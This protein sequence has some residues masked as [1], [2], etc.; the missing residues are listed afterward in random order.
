MGQCGLG[1]LHAERLVRRQGHGR[2]DRRAAQQRDGR[3]HRQARR[4]QPLRPGAGRGQ[5]DRARQAAAELDE[6]DHRHQGRQAGDG[7]RHAG[8]QPH[9]HRGAAHDHQRDRLRHE[10]AG[11]GRRAALPPAVAADATNVET[12]AL[13]PDTRKILE[14][15]G[16]KL[17]R[18]RSRPTT[19][20]RSWSARRR[21][22]ASRSARTATTAPT[23]RA[24]TRA[25]R[26][27]T[28]RAERSP[29]VN[30]LAGGLAAPDRHRST[31]PQRCAR[32][33]FLRRYLAR[34]GLP[35]ASS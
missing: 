6:P 11:G 22:A 9:H 23:I 10:R 30:G 35:R 25:S 13:S 31:S 29:S 15:M 4:A 20:R 24:A 27:A 21:S 18:R 19:S 1:H 8:R 26:S 32:P 33:P 14:G 7:R 12:F 3:L 28:D 17:R 5:R 2:R 34:R 16:H